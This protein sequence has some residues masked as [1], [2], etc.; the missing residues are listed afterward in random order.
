MRAVPDGAAVGGE[1]DAS[2]AVLGGP[3]RRGHSED[4]GTQLGGRRRY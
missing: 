1:G 4:G 2:G 3:V